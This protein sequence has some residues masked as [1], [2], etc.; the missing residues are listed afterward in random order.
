[1]LILKKCYNNLITVFFEK[2]INK[3]DVNGDGDIEIDEFKKIFFN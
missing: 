3:I 2:K 1:M